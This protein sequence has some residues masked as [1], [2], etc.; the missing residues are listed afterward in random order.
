MYRLIMILGIVAA[1]GFALGCGSSS[2][3]EAT[4]A[5]LTKDQF[6]KQAD[7]IC[8]EIAK[9]REAAADAWRKE[10]P[11]GAE[12]AEAHLEDGFKEIV[13][14]SW[15]KEAEELETLVP[16]KTDQAMVTRL[17]GILT[18]ASK[19]ME[20]GEAPKKV[21]AASLPQFEREA[22]SFGFRICSRPI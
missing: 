10:F 6:I 20:N 8:K 21:F 13:A 16:P 17:I 2:S 15:R 3:E 5:P 14:P 7:T 4:S 19:D 22:K 11:G 18:S 12:E 9:E 1:T